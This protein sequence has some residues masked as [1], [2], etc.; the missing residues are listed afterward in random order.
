LYK[1]GWLHGIEIVNGNAY[2]PLA[3]KWCLEKKLTMMGNT[4]S[5]NPTNLDYDFHNGE[6]RSMTLVLAKDKTKEAIKEA[7]F[8]RRTM[9]YW[10]NNLIGE[11]K[12][13]RP[14]FD[15][16]IEIINPAVEI[17]GR[18]W[19]HI[20]I[21]NKSEIDFELMAN[22]KVDDISVPSKLIL[23]GDKI[24]LLRIRARKDTP[25]GT[26]QIRIPYKVKNLLTGF[27]KNLA[28]ELVI[29]VDFISVEQK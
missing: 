6:H 12:Y 8:A 20:Q 10:K 9:V 24:S 28:V 15:K 25:P 5:H 4:D 2:E 11:E 21:R 7:L 19:A 14:I 13:L 17:K 3:H 22:G 23:Y 27:E 26:K 1:K 29:N 18:N 16:S